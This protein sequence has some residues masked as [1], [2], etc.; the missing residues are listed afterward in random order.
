MKKLL[1]ILC[2]LL[3]LFA[4]SQQRVRGTLIIDQDL[5]LPKF[6]SA[7]TAFL[8]IRANGYVDTVSV[9]Q[10]VNIVNNNII[11]G[12]SDTFYVAY[13]C[14]GTM[15]WKSTGD[16]IYI[17]TCMLVTTAQRDI[18]TYWDRAN[19]LLYPHYTGDSVRVDGTL[20]V[21]VIPTATSIPDPPVILVPGLN[22]RI[23]KIEF[24]T[25]GMSVIYD[26][27]V[28]NSTVYDTVTYD[29]T[30]IVNNSWDTTIYLA[31]VDTIIYDSIYVFDLVTVTINNYW[32]TT[33][34]DTT[35]AVMT[36]YD[37]TFDTIVMA[38]DTT[39]YDTTYVGAD[40]LYIDS[41]LTIAYDTTIYDT[42]YI[43]RDSLYVKYDTLQRAGWKYS[44]D[45]LFVDT[46]GTVGVDSLYAKYG[47]GLP[48]VSGWTKDTINIDTTAN[49]DSVYILYGQNLPKIA[50][51]VRNDTVFIDTIPA[52]ARFDSLLVNYG[53]WGTQT[54]YYVKNEGQILIDTV[55][56]GIINITGDAW[57]KLD[58]DSLYPI[59]KDYR[60]IIGDSVSQANS[61]LT[62]KGNMAV[63]SGFIFYK[64][65][66][67]YLH[68]YGSDSSNIFLGQNAG[69]LTTSDYNIIAIG[70]NAFQSITT[71]GRNN[72]AIG[73]DASKATTEPF[74]TISIGNYTLAKANTNQLNTVIGDST[75]SNTLNSSENTV[76]GYRVMPK[77]TGGVGNTV[78]GAYAL[79]QSTGNTSYN[80]A[81]GT[82]ALEMNV[83][84][85]QNIAI[86]YYAGWGSQGSKKL[87]IGYGTGSASDTAT[88]IIYGDMENDSLVINGKLSIAQGLNRFYTFP[89]NDGDP[90]QILK[91]G[92]DGKTIEW[93]NDSISTAS[94][95][96]YWDSLS[97]VLSPRNAMWTK[98]AIGDSVIPRNHGIFY[99]K[100]YIK[101]DISQNNTA[102]GVNT[103]A[104]IFNG[105]ANTAVGQD[106]LSHVVSG[107]NNQAYGNL[108]LSGNISGSHNSAFGDNTLQGITTSTYNTGI[109][110]AV[111][112]LLNS[113]TRN[114][115]LGNHSF[116]Q[117]LSGSNNVGIG[118]NAG[119]IITS[120]SGNIIIG[121]GAVG[122]TG[123]SATTSNAFVVDNKSS[124]KFTSFIYGDLLNDSIIFNSMVG[125]G[126]KLHSE[127]AYFFPR[128]KG[129][130][131]QVLAVPLT[132]NLLEWVDMSGGGNDTLWRHS[133]TG[134][135]LYP[136]QYVFDSIGIFTN[137]PNNRFQVAGLINFNNAKTS[138]ALGTNTLNSITTGSA[139]TAVGYNSQQAN[140]SGS[141]NTSMGTY[142]LQNK[143]GGSSDV[144]IGY[145]AMK[146]ATVSNLNTA[147]GTSAIGGSATFIGSNNTALG[148]SS[149]FN[150][151]LASRNTA[152]GVNTLFNNLTGTDNIAIGYQAGFSE[153]GSSK[154][155]ID[156]GISTKFS[157]FIY[158]DMNFAPGSDSLVIN[159]KLTV[160]D[161]TKRVY[162]FPTTLGTAGQ[163]LSAPVSGKTLTWTNPSSLIAPR[164]TFYVKY[165]T[166]IR[167][168]SPGIPPPI[169]TLTSKWK[170]IGD[171]I[172]MDTT[173]RVNN[174]VPTTLHI[175]YTC[176]DS[177]RF[178]PDNYWAISGDSILLDSCYSNCGDSITYD[179]LTHELTIC[180]TTYTI[181]WYDNWVKLTSN[182]RTWLNPRDNTNWN[183]GIGVSNPDEKLSVKGDSRFFYTGTASAVRIVQNTS[184]PQTRLSPVLW[185]SDSSVG[186]AWPQTA[187]IESYIGG[188]LNLRANG[189][190]SDI[191]ALNINTGSNATA[192]R[193]G[194]GTGTP[195]I[196][197]F[198]DYFRVSALGNTWIGGTTTINNIPYSL[199]DTILVDS[200]GVVKRKIGTTGG[201][202]G[203]LMW[204]DTTIKL[205]TKY[206][207]DTLSFLRSYSETDPVWIS[208]SADYLHKSD[209]NTKVASRKWVLDKGYITTSLFPRYL[210]IDTVKYNYGIGKGA[211]DSRTTGYGNIALG[212][213]ALKSNTNGYSNISMGI[214]SLLE[215]VSGFN[216][217]GIG[218]QTL[219]YNYS[220]KHNIAI[221]SLSLFNN[222]TGYGN[223]AIGA[224]SILNGQTDYSNIAIGDSSL[225]LNNGG[226][227]N[228]G[229]GSL[230][231]KNNTSGDYNTVVGSG[232]L[233]NGNAEYNV[234]IGYQTLNNVTSAGNYNTA[235]G[236]NAMTA[237]SN[238]TNNIALGYAAGYNNTLS[239]RLFIDAF[240]RGS[241]ALDTT[242]S[243]IYAYMDNAVVANQR[244]T[245]NS[246]L[247]FPQV[248]TDTAT[249][250]L[251]VQI[252]NNNK[253]VMKKLT[254][255]DSYF[256]K[257]QNHLYTT[258]A[259]DSLI[260][261]SS[262]NPVG[263]FE[264]AN[265]LKLDDA[266][267]SVYI[268]NT[269]GGTYDAANNNVA[270]GDA[271]LSF[272][273]DG[274]FNVGVG[275]N[276]GG[277][278]VD[279]VGN[280]SL[281]GGAMINAEGSYNTSVG[282]N[283]L[284]HDNTSYNNLAL[285]YKA[286]GYSHG[287]SSIYIGNYSGYWNNLNDR[288]FVNNKPKTN[289]AQDTTQSLLY[290]YF[291]AI[292][293]NQRLTANSKLFLPNISAQ[294]TAKY[295]LT[296]NIG[297]KEV[298]ASAI[299]K[300]HYVGSADSLEGARACS[301]GGTQDVYYKIV[302]GLLTSHDA[303]G[304]SSAGDSIKITTPG[305]Y[306][307]EFAISA[308]TQNANDKIRVKMYVN[309][310][311]AGSSLGRFIINSGGT[312]AES[313]ASYFWYKTFAGNDQITF[314]VANLTGSRAVIIKDYKVMVTRQ[315]E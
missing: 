228:V 35:Y 158:G 21:G 81:I 67:R 95:V 294:D 275:S 125:I 127:R 170:H 44:G 278:I 238:G 277:S 296:Y 297:T 141:S 140:V 5:G 142:A 263:L 98:V 29:T 80:T 183:I 266:G 314:R 173:F 90:G 39:I 153:T 213:S 58:G 91:L 83:N 42:V 25:A 249:Y 254:G 65:G 166:T 114:A 106:A 310:V 279:G 128:T 265:R 165:F 267:Y 300:E 257:L 115:V 52:V 72:I 64:N 122:D 252:A 77:V 121:A 236:T 104:S 138:T 23:E 34:Y 311:A 157:S 187:L 208:D 239:N 191:M 177:S 281:G 13:G 179:S 63:A 176:Y 76:V 19:N 36:V 143:T 93:R 303:T 288:F 182:G 4:V 108:A 282:Y 101:F 130:H 129:D 196:N 197:P 68:F 290:G 215:N 256:S 9:R 283:S 137:T 304:I 47:I 214:N 262:S 99:V 28:I 287:D 242:G 75:L 253:V 41:L 152:I 45:T 258:D 26:T 102:I 217:I 220:G 15:G 32:D 109:G 112:P 234:A 161:G 188:A 33:Y 292:A 60:V 280:T 113:G 272:L 84:G 171:T 82:G 212:D 86:G 160:G 69:N 289:T 119:N 291:N 237:C 92:L 269:A 89:F 180:D 117:M 10:L 227:N 230:A 40:T 70:K 38:Y 126:E 132:G 73:S 79:N 24:D 186:S 111:L 103:L 148:T 17:D 203:E 231:L 37:T 14:N 225:M 110:C 286:A 116:E 307:I 199:S 305:D 260:I 224:S 216:N 135:K 301:L 200:A 2:F 7:D 154:L 315:Q 312:G 201:G 49:A 293:A 308:T 133:V 313:T 247:Y 309:N 146:R 202:T 6:A 57:W 243:P 162:S 59:S 50:G 221:G 56:G 120:G 274:E 218:N 100:G 284:A 74:G 159:G 222:Q 78:V 245:F 55:Q 248:P 299:V 16:T 3:P 167:S 124:N 306:R 147:V 223:I 194:N 192:I 168:T 151:T 62:L 53:S 139:N 131:G 232:A 251:G 233:P 163:L 209:T 156:N 123:Y 94:F 145:C 244:T 20:K 31:A 207:L 87:F 264:V 268:G 174:V 302:T 107:R 61:H 88:S 144:A 204:S 298:K 43:A 85:D 190:R 175:I 71:E 210:I 46:T 271:A 273:G 255:A 276:A 97:G 198:N 240:N 189:S 206:D 250:M 246:K 27:L 48:Q 185:V 241:L 155:Y 66:Q 226:H 229:I 261:G 96:Q 219:K 18:T 118:V 136:R 235:V 295:Y 169:P 30:I 181:T 270:V 134:H 193:V 184:L 8:F 12:K 105:S 259:N 51:W 205:G 150:A 211:L 285:G 172:Y 164:D 54:D 149:L 195:A 178:S 11:V 22:G 1:V